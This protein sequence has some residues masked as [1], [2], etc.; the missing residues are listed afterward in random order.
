MNLLE[1]VGWRRARI[2]IYWV[3][4]LVLVID[5][6]MVLSHWLSPLI[7]AL[8]FAL[9]TAAFHEQHREKDNQK[10]A[11][12]ADQNPLPVVKAWLL[13]PGVHSKGQCLV[14]NVRLSE[15]I[16]ANVELS[17]LSHIEVVVI[18]EN[19]KELLEEHTSKD[20]RAVVCL[21]QVSHLQDASSVTL[22]V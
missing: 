10:T 17:W 9:L 22:I 11:T 20:D 16:K 4:Q 13:V 3:D 19:S 2:I 7:T 15:H 8:L 6:R 21:A 18:S 1:S 12:D 14:S 5:D